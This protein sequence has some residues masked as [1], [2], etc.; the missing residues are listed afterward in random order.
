MATACSP[1]GSPHPSEILLPVRD[2]NL[3]ATLDSGQV[4][5]WRRVAHQVRRAEGPERIG[6]EWWRGAIEAKL[7]R[8]YY[9]VEDEDGR[10]FWLY[11]AGLYTPE[12]PAR[13]FMHGLFA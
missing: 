1:G 8:D 4:F 5:R 6:G 2:Y 7:L 9:R 10:R 12:K 3:A 11:R 13:W